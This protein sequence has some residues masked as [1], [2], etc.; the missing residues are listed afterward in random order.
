MNSTHVRT[1]AL[2]LL[3]SASPALLAQTPATNAADQRL[4]ALYD[5]E[6]DWRQKEFARVPGEF[7]SHADDDH[8]PRVDAGTQAKRLAYWQKT[9]ADLDRIPLEQL[10]PEEKINAQVFRAVIEE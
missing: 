8:L 3:L 5:A 6:W 2:A 9:L 4:K 1:L 7:G 10:S